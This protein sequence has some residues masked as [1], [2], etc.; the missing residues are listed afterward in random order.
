M[1]R[2]SDKFKE[3]KGQG[4]PGIKGLRDL[5]DL[6][7]LREAQKTQH[8]QL[9]TQN[10]CRTLGRRCSLYSVLCTLYFFSKKKQNIM[11]SYEVR[12][13]Q[14]H[15]LKILIA[16]DKVCKEHG[17]R[18]YLAAGT[19]LGA[20]RHKGFIPWD[21]DVDITMPRKDY[22]ILM[23]HGNEW[24]PAPYEMMDYRTKPDYPFGFGKVVDY[25]TTLVEREHH[26]LV[27]G[28][29]L[30][31]FP[32]DPIVTNKWVQRIHTIR[33]S[34]YKKVAYLL[35]RNPYKHG[36]GPSCWMPLL[37]RRL[38]NL[39]DIMVKMERLQR[40]YEGQETG[41]VIDH[42]FGMRGILKEEVL[43]E[44]VDVTFEGLTFNGVAQ[45][46][47][48]LRHLYGDYMVIPTVAQQHRHDFYWLDYEHPYR[49]YVEKREF[50]FGRSPKKSR[51][52]SRE[53][54]E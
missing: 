12:P 32:L 2:D 16:V 14:L 17:L 49:E 25:S 13:L 21:D 37:C 20:V 51:V 26:A 7:D 6:K 50:V 47:E 43:G 34:F 36:H 46:D 30:D 33:F 45:Y 10:S 9:T 44:P 23:A 19:M 54:R 52:E 1:F 38:F 35:S 31:I 24:L 28:V 3:F 5:R 39:K 11:A 27:D 40:K 4:A 15:I 53:S 22:E 8:S 42:D 48:Y 41:W 29:Y 18:Y